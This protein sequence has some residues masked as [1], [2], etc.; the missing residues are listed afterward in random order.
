MVSNW[1]KSA[2]NYAPNVSLIVT[3]LLL[4]PFI[5][6]EDVSSESKCT[7]LVLLMAVF[8][9]L[10][11]IPLPITSLFPIVLLPL[12]GLASTETACGSYLKANNMLFFGCL[13][14]ALA[15][16]KSNLH[17]RIALK[18]LLSISYKF[19]LISLC[20]MMT[21]M[22]F[23]MWIVS[24]AT[25]AMMLPIADEIFNHLFTY[26][27]YNAKVRPLTPSPQKIPIMFPSVDVDFQKM[28][29][30]GQ[31]SLIKYSH[32]ENPDLW[33]SSE[34]KLPFSDS[35][36]KPETL[37][38]DQKKQVR[39]LFYLC[40]AYAATIGSVSTLTSNGPNLIMKD[41]LEK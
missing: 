36:D 5:I 19:S 34:H 38:E 29:N 41:I 4:L 6:G 17:Q 15:I 11:P 8:W 14:L 21:T 26:D 9:T 7:F 12:L 10:N 32:N 35:A 20:F 27:D 24:T 28:P 18:V 3:P 25:V 13:T 37:S 23:S 1:L 39:K 33:Y 22:C 31:A 16:E 2:I 30:G 40:I